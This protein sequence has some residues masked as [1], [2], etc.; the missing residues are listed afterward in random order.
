M[1]LFKGITLKKLFIAAL[2]FASSTLF[3]QSYWEMKKEAYGT[4][5]SGDKRKAFRVIDDFI[6]KHPKEYKAQNLSAVLHYWSGEYQKSKGILEKIV[7]ST[8]F[9]EASKLLSRI[10]AKMGKRSKQKRTS[11]KAIRTANKKSQSTDLEYLVS[12]V[13]KNPQDIKNR[14]LLSKFY[15]K[16]Q[17]F[18]KSYD[19]AH[20]VLEI[21]PHN[22][23]MKT[24]TAHLEKQYK[25]SYSGMIDDESVVDKTKA[26]AMLA[27][28]YH[29]KKYNAYFNLYD[30]L[31]NAHVAFS[32]S[33][34]IDILHVAI[35]I[36]KYQEAQSLIE[37]GVLPVNKQTLKVQLL[38]SKKLS[39]SVASR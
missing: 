35:M 6:S 30:A 13:E 33:E 8:D 2:V 27:K 12:Q 37:K 18:Q 28:L 4:Y 29:D 3:A 23:K 1:K 17:E 36:G 34:Y 10:N 5:K 7:A 9:P 16:I 24:I 21:N 11:Y 39:H 31:K 19:L 25:L 26:K 38:L 20:E 22:K 32:Q 15:F 14:V